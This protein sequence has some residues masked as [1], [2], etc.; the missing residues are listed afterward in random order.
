MIINQII[1][2]EYFNRTGILNLGKCN[3]SRIPDAVYSM[4][5]LE[6]LN[7]SNSYL[8]WD[9][10]TSSWVNQNV[11]S[12]FPNNFI[13]SLSSQIANLKRLRKLI[14]CGDS[15]STWKIN[16]LEPLCDLTN[17]EVLYFANNQIEDLSPLVHLKHLKI[18]GGWNNKISSVDAV[19]EHSYL[20]VVSLWRNKIKTVKPFFQ[21]SSIRHVDL[22][23]NAL[24]KIALPE[25]ENQLAYLDISNNYISDIHHLVPFSQANNLDILWQK[26]FIRGISVSNNPLNSPPVE[27]VKQGQ[28]AINCFFVEKFEGG[29]EKIF[30]AKLIIVGQGGAGKTTLVRKLV[31]GPKAAMPDENQS[32]KGIDIQKYSVPLHDDRSLLF[33]V[34]DFGGQEIYYATHQFFLTR[35]S[36]YILVDD[37][38]D[39][40]QPSTP[41]SS[42]NYWLQVIELL[43]EGSPVLII[44]NEKSDR[45]KGLDEP[46]MRKRY[47][48]IRRILRTNLLTGRGLEEVS[49]AIKEEAMSLPHIEDEVPRS[50]LSIRRKLEALAQEKDY[51]SLERFLEICAAENVDEMAAAGLS[52]Y[53]HDLGI[54]LHYRDDLLLRNF[55]ILRHD[56][57]TNAV[58][59]LLDDERIRTNNGLF[60]RETLDKT[61][62]LPQYRF[63]HQELLNLMQRFELCFPLYDQTHPQK[64]A[65]L[66]PL[67]LPAKTPKLDWDDI[68]NAICK[69]KYA[70]MPKGIIPRLI[71]RKYPYLKDINKAWQHGAVLNFKSTQALII[72][73]FGSQEILIKCCGEQ[74]RPFLTMI[75]EDLERINRQFTSRLG[76]KKFIPC[77]CPEC[78]ENPYPYF[79]KEEDLLLRQSRDVQSIE[80][81]RSLRY[82]L[83]SKVLAGVKVEYR[84]PRIF[85]SYSSATQDIDSYNELMK[86][87]AVLERNDRFESWHEHKI[88]FGQ[89]RA[90]FRQE[91]LEKA[92]IIFFLLSADFLGDHERWEGELDIAFKRHQEGKALIIPIYL[93]SVSTRDTPFHEIIG[94]PK[95]KQP[96]SMAEDKDEA[97]TQ[98]GN[99]IRRIIEGW[100]N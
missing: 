97:F 52:H 56:W 58:Y 2:K 57:A 87:L 51:I 4:H 33:H 6:E 68:N 20:Q 75:T 40:S 17:L 30:E 95:D 47:P 78:N 83:I 79:F 86:H 100:E 7:L 32:T 5:W 64:K 15:D 35:R 62:H 50:W 81:G 73:E 48:N 42:F 66:T 59:K 24:T 44:Q 29:M 80:C 45:S 54:F 90:N 99:E 88:H 85:I 10:T 65:W 43:G 46:S 92:D 37:T 21:S 18:L 76:V 91:Q 26:N 84:K 1:E 9:D 16:S 39:Y 72:H 13:G 11:Q 69:Y 82:V 34:W 27:I 8:D 61:W 28:K 49:H 60:Y 89:S 55:F 74:A 67:M 98:I 14:I 63:K 94:L 3:L 23:Y 41:H 96:I 19:L 71:I 53:L 31:E 36:L 38:R 22:S 25:K 77:C 93:R 70:F 12:I